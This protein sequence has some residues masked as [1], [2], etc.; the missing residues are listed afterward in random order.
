MLC[1][2]RLFSMIFPPPLSHC[3]TISGISSLRFLAPTRMVSS[4]GVSTRETVKYNSLPLFAC[5]DDDDDGDDDDDAATWATMMML[6][7]LMWTMPTTMLMSIRG[8]QQ[9]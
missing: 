1:S 5:K 9:M 6:M 4:R 2:A 7:M 8:H 3:S